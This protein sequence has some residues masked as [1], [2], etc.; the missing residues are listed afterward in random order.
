[1]EDGEYQDAKYT[2][3]QEDKVVN[4]EIKDYINNSFGDYYDNKGIKDSEDSDEENDNI[5][6]EMIG[7]LI[8]SL[9]ETM[10]GMRCF[11]NSFFDNIDNIKDKLDIKDDDIKDKDNKEIKYYSANYENL[12]VYKN[13]LVIDRILPPFIELQFLSTIK[14]EFKDEKYKVIASL[15][16]INETCLISIVANKTY[17]YF[18]QHDFI[19][20]KTEAKEKEFSTNFIKLIDEDIK[21][22][23]FHL[24]MDDI[25]YD[26][27]TEQ[28]KKMLNK[29]SET[30]YVFISDD[31]Y[32]SNI[33]C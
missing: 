22:R 33:H 12:G 18:K 6:L 2:D 21:K 4:N 26:Y 10:K 20:P 24:K 17:H 16:N 30:V 19:F 11:D 1:M 9:T 13:D 31:Y 29:V 15:F 27:I 32:H 25:Y 28:I 3:N 23:M 5:N 7:N 14:Q 8:R